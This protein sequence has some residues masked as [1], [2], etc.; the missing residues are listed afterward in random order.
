MASSS[1]C[2]AVLFST[3]ML[4]SKVSALSDDG[5]KILKAVRRIRGGDGDRVT[6]AAAGGRGTSD[7]A[8]P[9]SLIGEGQAARCVRAGGP[10]M[11]FA[12]APAHEDALHTEPVGLDYTGGTAF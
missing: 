8:G 12:A 4:P 11:P 2:D 3:S 10:A 9:V 7:D 1:G 6:A 5:Q